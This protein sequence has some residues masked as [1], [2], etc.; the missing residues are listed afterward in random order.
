[1]RATMLARAAA[2]AALLAAA[3]PAAA[4][5]RSTTADPQ[6]PTQGVCLWWG[7]PTISYVVNTAGYHGNCGTAGALA[8]VRASFESWNDQS[9]SSLHF[10]P[11]TE[12]T[13][14][15]PV[16][17]GEGRN[18][19][20]FREGFCASANG[21]TPPHNP[22]N[23]WDHDKAGATALTI[24]LTTTTFQVS[25]GQIIDADMELRSWSGQTATAIPTRGSSTDGLYFTCSDVPTLCQTYG[26]PSCISMDIGTTVT[27]EAGHVL[28]LDHVC[29]YPN[30]PASTCSNTAVM[31]P[32]AGVGDVHRT[33]AQDDVNGVCAIY[34][35]GKAPD[36]VTGCLSQQASASTSSGGGCA[37]GGA[38][39]LGLV[40]LALAALR[41]RMARP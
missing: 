29:S 14:T 38:G 17:S 30:A 25:T 6:D 8:L 32:T 19:V 7:N 10:N 13:S 24:A 21:T 41:R 26:Q 5:V 11:P 40:G 35:A 16:M 31:N 18:T 37:T 36:H 9:C 27:H 33:L 22:N 28:G 23:C 3:A 12:D 39:A 4:F 1:M 34:P 15:T 2:I 20:I